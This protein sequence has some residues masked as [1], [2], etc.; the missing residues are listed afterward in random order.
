MT[1]DVPLGVVGA[2]VLAGAD[3]ARRGVGVDLVVVG[4]H[5]GDVEDL[6]VAVVVVEVSRGAAAAVAST[7]AAAAAQ[8]LNFH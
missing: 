8:V 4:V 3:A 7:E 1:T 6:A 2:A 5:Q